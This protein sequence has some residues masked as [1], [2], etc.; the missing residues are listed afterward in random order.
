MTHS[1]MQA[2][3]LVIGA[4]AMG[5]AFAD[6]ILNRDKKATIIMVDRRDTLGGHWNDAYEHVHLHQPKA[7]YGVN[8][9]VLGDGS[10]DLSSKSE[11]LEYYADVL[12]DFEA[13]GRFTFLKSHEYL[14]DGCVAPLSVPDNK[15][16]ITVNRRIVNATFMGVEIPKTHPPKFDVEDGVNFVPPNN[17]QTDY[18]NWETF[19]V[20]GCGKTGMDAVLVLLEN[21]VSPD[22]ITWV[23][24][25]EAWCFDRVQLS[26]GVVTK[27]LIQHF[28]QVVEQSDAN[29]IFMEIEKSGGIVRLNEDETPTKW[30]C[31][32]VNQQ[33]MA[34]LRTI[35]Q[36]I[37]QGRIAKLTKTSIEFANGTSVPHDGKALFVNCTADGLAARMPEPIFQ[38]GLIQLQSILFCQQVFSAAAIARL[39]LQKM[40]DQKRNRVKPVPHPV[41]PQDWP[42][43][44]SQSVDNVLGLHFIF[45]LW[46]F[47]ARLNFMSHEPLW[48]YGL[49]AA[50]TAL[51]AGAIRREAHSGKYE[52]N[53]VTA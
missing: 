36:V 41:L 3:Y 23:R 4:G 45:P 27:A 19:T 22:A 6:E 17:L 15:V 8:S 37:R 12:A 42:E 28:Q 20:L 10:N 32:T 2:D 33:E 53:K 35:K 16:Q 1:K 44:V 46:M 52:V 39:E 21:G 49:F 31:A 50:R 48:Q 30:R 38:P 26:T 43:L 40:S 29:E 25:N 24:P 47:N 11:I 7:F 51:L 14:G 5:A 9:R 13:T 18:K 34:Q